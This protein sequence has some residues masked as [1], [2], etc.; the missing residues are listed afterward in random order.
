MVTKP[1]PSDMSVKLLFSAGESNTVCRIEKYE[2]I[3]LVFYICLW[4][5]LRMSN[6]KKIHEDFVRNSHWT[7]KRSRVWLSSAKQTHQ[8]WMLSWITYL[9]LT[10]SSFIWHYD[11]LLN[12]HMQANI[13]FYNSSCQMRTSFSHSWEI[14]ELLLGNHRDPE[15]KMQKNSK[16]IGKNG[17]A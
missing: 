14:I 13:C 3:F 8:I 12:N 7:K 5:L 2:N 1:S 4:L 15:L 10:L 11:F 17:I 6:A 9:D 16:V